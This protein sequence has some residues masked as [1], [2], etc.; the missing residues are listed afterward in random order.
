MMNCTNVGFLKIVA[1]VS[2]PG[3]AEG[4]SVSRPSK[5]VLPCASVPMPPFTL[6]VPGLGSK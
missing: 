1:P 2:N 6:T 4:D 3:A 5:T